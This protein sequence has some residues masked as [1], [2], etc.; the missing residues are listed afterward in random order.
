M[1]PE[2]L[3]GDRSGQAAPDYRGL[4]PGSIERLDMSGSYPHKIA[5][6][7]ELAYAAKRAA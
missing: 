1:P 4:P 2:S 6:A 5:Y 3:W 7:A